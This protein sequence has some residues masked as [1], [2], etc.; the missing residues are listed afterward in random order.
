MLAVTMLPGVAQDI[1][2][3]FKE[4]KSKIPV[5]P[6]STIA[7]V[8]FLHPSS[9]ISNNEPNHQLKVKRGCFIGVRGSVK[10]VNHVPVIP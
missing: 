8:T 7:A 10:Q 4:A 1:F 5:Y 3:K 2:V 6:S 9:L